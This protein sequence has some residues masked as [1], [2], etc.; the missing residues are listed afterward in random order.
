MR[1]WRNLNSAEVGELQ[2]QRARVKAHV[3]LTYRTGLAQCMAR[4]TRNCAAPPRETTCENLLR[5][6]AL[7]MFYS[8]DSAYV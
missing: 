4:A 1:P 5:V 8:P 2:F 3:P 6:L 7:P